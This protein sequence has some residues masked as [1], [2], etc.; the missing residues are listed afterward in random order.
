MEVYPR[1]EDWLMRRQIEQVR[2]DGELCESVKELVSV[3]P[4]VDLL[5]GLTVLT[6]RAGILKSFL[7]CLR[8]VGYRLRVAGLTN[9][10]EVQ[11]HAKPLV[12]LPA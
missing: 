12:N 9:T 10:S 5:D 4:A 11:A 3:D 7:E 6:H 8:M 1:Q 2:K